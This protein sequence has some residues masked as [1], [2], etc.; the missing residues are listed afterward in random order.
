M[1]ATEIVS[2][3]NDTVVAEAELVR[4]VRSLIARQ[5][6]ADPNSGSGFDPG[7]LTTPVAGRTTHHPARVTTTEMPYIV[8]Y[9]AGSRPNIAGN[10]D[11]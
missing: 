5:A 1:N 11:S 3:T 2:E 9:I 6:T 10:T 8:D 4:T 7:V